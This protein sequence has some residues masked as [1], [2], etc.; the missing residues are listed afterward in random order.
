MASFSFPL[1]KMEMCMYVCL[2]IACAFSSLCNI[3]AKK[4]KVTHAAARCLPSRKAEIEW[5]ILDHVMVRTPRKA[6]KQIQD[7]NRRTPAER[8]KRLAALP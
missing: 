7:S 2:V 3:M 6:L 4:A 8:G 5:N 1:R